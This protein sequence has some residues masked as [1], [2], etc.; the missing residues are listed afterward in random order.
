MYLREPKGDSGPS[1]AGRAGQPPAGGP[2]H[3][4]GGPPRPSKEALSRVDDRL[5][6]CASR[7]AE[8]PG[9]RLL[10]TGAQCRLGR[11]H[12]VPACRERVGARREYAFRAIPH[13]APAG[14]RRAATL[15]RPN[16]PLGPRCPIREPRIR[17]GAAAG[18]HR[19]EH[20]PR[21][22]LLGQ[23][24]GRVLFSGRS[25]RSSAVA[26]DGRASLRHDWRWVAGFRS[27]TTTSAYTRR[28]ASEV[29]SSTR[30]VHQA[31]MSEAA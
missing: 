18:R 30:Q 11:G 5:G 12:P 1:Q 19:S 8:Y 16:S 9:A 23:R 21:G 22:Q 25:S 27:S 20:E 7:G 17:R 15:G 10:S 13:R 31:S 29:P 6:A 24:C 26:L 4:C 28:S 2:P 3:A 14:R